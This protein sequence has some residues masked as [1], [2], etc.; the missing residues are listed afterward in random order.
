MISSIGEDRGND[1]C[2][3]LLILVQISQI[4]APLM[5]SNLEVSIKISMAHT[6]QPSISAADSTP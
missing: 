6:P 2:A 4:S 5:V 1:H 3:T